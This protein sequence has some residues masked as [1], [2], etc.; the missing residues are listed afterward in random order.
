[1]FKRNEITEAAHT[2]N[3]W[4]RYY[5]DGTTLDSGIVPVIK[6]DTDRNRFYRV[7]E[8]G[9]WLILPYDEEN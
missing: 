2:N 7:T 3:V 6:L 8:A 9:D 5:I 4:N 1:M